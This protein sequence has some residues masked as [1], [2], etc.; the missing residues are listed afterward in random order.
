M[1]SIDAKENNALTLQEALVIAELRKNS[2]VQNIGILNQKIHQ[3]KTI[4]LKNKTLGQSSVE[5]NDQNILVDIGKEIGLNL[6]P[7]PLFLK[8]CK[9]I[10]VDRI[11]KI[12]KNHLNQIKIYE[13]DIK[14]MGRE[15]SNIYFCPICGG[16]GNIVRVQH[17]REGRM[18][19]TLRHPQECSF[20]NGKGKLK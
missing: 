8:L 4:I 3:T 11:E 2:L 13:R 18:V 20:C 10:I 14:T 6:N 16:S 5:T 9:E 17:H 19:R 7:S 15:I 12:N 1:S